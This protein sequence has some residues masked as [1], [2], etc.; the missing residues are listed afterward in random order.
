MLK[1]VAKS[2]Y[3]GPIGILGHTQHDVELRLQDNLDG[4]AWLVQQLDGS[5]PG[6]RPGYRTH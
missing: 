1:V 3:D 4:L 6:P 5:G 2:G